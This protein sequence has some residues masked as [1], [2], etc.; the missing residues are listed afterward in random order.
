MNEVGRFFHRV[1]A[2]RHYEA[3]DLVAV[4]VDLLHELK[5]HV[6]GHVLRTDLNDLFRDHIGDFS[7][8]RNGSNQVVDGDLTRRISRTRCRLTGAG[9]RAARCQH[10]NVRQSHGRSTGSQQG[11]R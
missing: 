6:I 7:Q 9:D 5:P 10:F 1:R 3:V 8:G 11:G 4:G 2:V